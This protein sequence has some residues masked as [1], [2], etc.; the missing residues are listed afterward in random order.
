MTDECIPARKKNGEIAR[1]TTAQIRMHKALEEREGPRPPGMICRHLCKNDSYVYKR[2]N[3]FI[4]VLHTT[5][6]TI[7]E[8]CADKSPQAKAAGGKI[9]GSNPNNPQ[10]LQVTCPHCGKTG[11]KMNMMQWHFDRCRHKHDSV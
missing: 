1:R 8:N 11:Q 9:G 4:C 5:W 7:E 6:G 3:G 2:E 10:K